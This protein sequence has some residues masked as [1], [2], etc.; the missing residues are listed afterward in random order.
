M[1]RIA[2]TFHNTPPVPALKYTLAIIIISAE[3][4]A[5]QKSYENSTGNSDDH[6]LNSASVGNLRK[7]WFLCQHRK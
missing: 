3:N 1:A 2:S 4:Y 7:P 6:K 5:F